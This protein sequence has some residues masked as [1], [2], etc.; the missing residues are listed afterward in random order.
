MAKEKDERTSSNYRID[1][2]DGY[3]CVKDKYCYTL[4]NTRD[5]K[6]TPLNPE[7]KEGE[8]TDKLLGYYTEIDSMLWAIIRNEVDAKALSKKRN[9]ELSEYV[10]IYENVRDEILNLTNINV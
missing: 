8:T 10:T 2:C 7:V 5:K 4:Y 1:I 6:A 3:F 9:L